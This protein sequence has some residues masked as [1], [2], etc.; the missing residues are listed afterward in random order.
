MVRWV[1]SKLATLC[2]MSYTEKVREG[3]GHGV[4]TVC[5]VTGV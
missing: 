4:E 1:S 3:E 2:L 5:G